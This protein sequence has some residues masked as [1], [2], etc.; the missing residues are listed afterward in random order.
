MKNGWFQVWEHFI[1]PE[2]KKVLKW[3][4]GKKKH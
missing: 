4:K 2:T 3:N 1:V